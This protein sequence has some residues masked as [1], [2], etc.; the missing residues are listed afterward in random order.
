[1]M[2]NL[3]STA[4]LCDRF[5]G[6]P[7]GLQV[8]APGLQ[9][10]GGRKAYRG[11]IATAAPGSAGGAVRLRDILSEPG[12]GRVLVVN[13]HACERWAVLGDQ[14]AALGHRHGWAGVVLNGYVRDLRA[15]AGIDIGVHALGA[16]PSRPQEF[17]TAQ[18]GIPL[19]FRRTRFVP[20]SWLFAD[21]DGIVVCTD[22]QAADS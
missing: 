17:D 5:L 14:L 15:L 16:V 11:R 1:M 22:F 8:V 20:G 7:D 10:F 4:D 12:D 6:K 2:E 19:E 13:G 21:E 18:R 3:I 9:S